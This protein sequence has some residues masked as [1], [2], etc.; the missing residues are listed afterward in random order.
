V[1]AGL[2]GIISASTLVIE[3]LLELIEMLGGHPLLGAFLD[4]GIEAKGELGEQL[5]SSLQ[6]IV[7]D[8]LSQRLADG[9]EDGI[10]REDIDV[11][12]MIAWICRILGTYLQRDNSDLSVSDKLALRRE[13]EKMLIP[14]LLSH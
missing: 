13:L 11:A 9:Q 7:H 3:T 14:S 6:R 12:M 10:I 1:E 4:P 8:L 2:H 5:A